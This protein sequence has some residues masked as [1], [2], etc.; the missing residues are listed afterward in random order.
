MKIALFDSGV[1]TSRK[2][3]DSLRCI[4]KNTSLYKKDQNDNIG[5]GTAIAYILQKKIKNSIIVS[6]KIFD[7]KVVTDEKDV[8]NALRDVLNNEPEI[9]IINISS[10]IAYLKHYEDFYN[11]CELLR[12][13]GC[14]IVSAFDNDGVISYPAAFDNTIGVFWET[15]LKKV[16]SFYYVENSNVEILGYAGNQLLPW[17]EVENRYVAGSS[18]VVP[19]IVAIIANLFADVKQL[20]LEKVKYQLKK[21]AND[22]IYNTV[23][24]ENEQKKKRDE[25]KLIKKA[26]LFPVNKET[27]A[28]IAN[29]DLLSFELCG[30][31]DYRYSNKIGSR[32][33]SFIHIN[34]GEDFVV[35]RLEE[36]DWHEDFDT[37]IV[38]HLEKISTIMEMDL[39]KELL[40]KCTLYKKNIYSFDGFVDASL[41]SKFDRDGCYVWTHY[42][43]NLHIYNCFCGS[44]HKL[45]SPVLAIIGTSSRQGKYNL[46]LE[47]RRRLLKSEYNVGQIG[48]EPS[49]HLLGMDVVFSNGYNNLYDIN[50]EEEIRYINECAF[51]I[52]MKDII[53]VG[54]QSNTIPLTYG[55]IGFLTIHQQN[56]LTATEPDAVILCVNLDDNVDYIRRTILVTENLYITKV[57]AIVI[58]PI[59]KEMQWNTN[60]MSTTKG[61]K[62]QL[63]KTKKILNDQFNIPVFINGNEEDMERLF[64]AVIDFF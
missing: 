8:I 20:D 40:D 21:I 45:A 10:G 12:K 60:Y 56:I 16:D 32:T 61:S 58:F 18:F 30:V 19:H 64:C 54:T 43:N 7:Q 52:G 38:G 6:Y 37:L 39:R 13:R 47:L 28:I 4:Q 33:S 57:I 2:E 5:H 63:E 22:I 35:K 26:V 34:Y 1:C 51:Q 62:N 48:T 50:S 24:V 53:L 3:I 15:T 36:I 25:V 44:C 41:K 23:A 31:Y 9:S 27:H 11:V 59:N 17:G 42:I 55:N 49:A 14:I 29:Q 46:Q